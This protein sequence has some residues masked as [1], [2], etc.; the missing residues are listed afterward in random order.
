MTALVRLFTSEGIDLGVFSVSSDRPPTR[1]TM[2][3][4]QTPGAVEHVKEWSPDMEIPEYDF[5]VA[6]QEWRRS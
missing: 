6:S 5:Y 1:I 3:E 2:D 4:W